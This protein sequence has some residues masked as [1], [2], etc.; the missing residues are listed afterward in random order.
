MVQLPENDINFYDFIDDHG[1]EKNGLPDEEDFYEFYDTMEVL[2]KGLSSVV[3]RCVE[4]S[5]GIEYAVKIMD[6]SDDKT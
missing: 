2:G 1:E 5:S 3:R 6:V 4:K